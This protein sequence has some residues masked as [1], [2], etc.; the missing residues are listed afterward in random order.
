MFGLLKSFILSNFL[1]VLLA[2]TVAS[3]FAG[4][5]AVRIFY[6]ASQLREY[7]A[8]Q[9]KL[10]EE[11]IRANKIAAN[12]EIDL[13]KERAKRDSIERE[14]RDE[15]KNPDYTNCHVPANGVRILQGIVGKSTS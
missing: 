2:S 6:Q 3:G 12:L 13:A 5:Y 11:R 10:N 15:L 14:L 9:E 8:E 4:G 7:R 1:W